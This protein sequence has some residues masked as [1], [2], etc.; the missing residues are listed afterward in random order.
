[1]RTLL[2][3]VVIIYLVGVG[4]ELSPT[5]STQWNSAPAPEFATNVA[6]ELPRALAWP[7]WS[8]RSAGEPDR[9]QT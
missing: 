6:L 3:L 5:I 1:M 7:A 4:I 2:A 8:F 9:S